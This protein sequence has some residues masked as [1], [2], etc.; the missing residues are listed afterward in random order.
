M[1]KDGLRKVAAKESEEQLVT[2]AGVRG[3]FARDCPQPRAHRVQ[4]VAH[5]G[6]A[7]DFVDEWDEYDYYEQDFDGDDYYQ[8]EE[9]FDEQY[10][11]DWAGTSPPYDLK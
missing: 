11:G 1:E 7:E 2:I 5:D 3:T 10:A 8:E 6:D 4:L 9:T